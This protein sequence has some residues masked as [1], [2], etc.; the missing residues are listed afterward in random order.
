MLVWSQ[1]RNLPN[2]IEARASTQLRERRSAA[3]PVFEKHRCTWWPSLEASIT[4]PVV[5]NPPDIL[6]RIGIIVDGSCPLQHPIAVVVPDQDLHI[7]QAGVVQGG[8]QVLS[9][10]IALLLGGVE[11]RLPALSSLRLILHGHAPYVHAR[12]LHLLHE[13]H[14]VQGPSASALR[15]EPPIAVEHRLRFHPRRRA[16]GTCKD[17]QGAAR[18]LAGRLD[19]RQDALPVPVDA[20]PAQVRVLLQQ[21]PAS[22][23]AQPKVAGADWQAPKSEP[24]PSALVKVRA[25][26]LRPSLRAHPLQRHCRCLGEAASETEEG[27]L[28]LAA[29][30]DKDRWRLRPA[31]SVRPQR[32]RPQRRQPPAAVPLRGDHRDPP[33]VLQHMRAN[34]SPCDSA[35]GRS[36]GNR[37]RRGKPC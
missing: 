2:V 25:Q 29:R 14:E 34:R 18:E 36:C 15:Q 13:P 3:L 6:G 1:L 32:L 4:I 11:A 26:N 12:L 7:L 8:A 35:G 10:K 27:L 17:R 21:V 5:C 19:H 33:V 24:D 22:P 31:R 37:G 28:V 23:V 20:E 30:V 9:H 16:P